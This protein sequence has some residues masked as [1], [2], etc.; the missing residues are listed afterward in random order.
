MTDSFTWHNGIA[1]IVITHNKC[2]TVHNIFADNYY[3][4]MK[5][6]V[7]HDTIL[8]ILLYYI[9]ASDFTVSIISAY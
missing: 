9:C 7:H 3:L 6:N 5:Q 8:V 4:K 2:L 1:C